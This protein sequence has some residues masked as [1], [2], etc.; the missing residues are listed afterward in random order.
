MLMLHAAG[1]PYLWDEQVADH[2]P[3]AKKNMPFGQL[4]VLVHSNQMVAQ[5]GTIVRYCAKLA[6]IW[7]SEMGAWA[8]ADMLIEHCNDIFNLMSKAKHAGDDSA[9][10][11]A[12]AEFADKQYPGHLA[13][14]SDMLGMDD[15]FG[16]ERPDAGDVAVFSII[17][18]A[19]RAGV[20][21][22]E[23][24]YPSLVAHS[25]R[26]SQLGTIRDYLAAQHP[27]YFKAPTMPQAAT[28]VG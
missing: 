10:M 4:P 26:V 27:V 24:W 17:N 5:S 25:K 23:G 11:K 15:Y 9:Q 28:V 8:K 18:L 2:W 3:E 13:W 7:P 6:G 20:D 12:W 19:V 16:G 1:L 21:F 14:L 22:S